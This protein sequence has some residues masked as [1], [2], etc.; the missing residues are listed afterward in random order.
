MHDECL[1]VDRQSVLRGVKGIIAHG[2]LFLRQPV[3]P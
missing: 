2:M 3:D 1:A